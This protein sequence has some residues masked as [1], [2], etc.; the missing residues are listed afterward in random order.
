MPC[1]GCD[2]QFK[3]NSI[4][5]HLAQKKESCRSQY[6]SAEF[7]ELQK[8]CKQS[9]NMKMRLWNKR[10]ND[11]ACHENQLEET[12][13]DVYWRNKEPVAKLATKKVKIKPSAE[14]IKCVA[15]HQP[16]PINKILRHVSHVK[17][18][19]NRYSSKDLHQLRQ[20][21]RQFSVNAL[22]F[23]KQSKHIKAK[24][25]KKSNDHEKHKLSNYRALKRKIEDLH[26]KCVE[27]IDM[28]KICHYK[29]EYEK[30]KVKSHQE[31]QIKYLDKLELLLKQFDTKIKGLEQFVENR[32]LEIKCN[33]SKWCF[34][35]TVKQTAERLYED[36]KKVDTNC[37]EVINKVQ[38]V[39]HNVLFLFHSGL[40]EFCVEIG[41]NVKVN[42]YKYKHQH[43]WEYE[44]NWRRDENPDYQMPNEDEA[45]SRDEFIM[46]EVE[47]KIKQ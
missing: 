11:T 10:R 44:S 21:C 37:K 28:D 12:Y 27:A 39:Y 32:F 40:K 22:A 25:D 17:E 31:F 35:D 4:L 33:T 47:M 23:K 7:D 15:C 34:D 19:K 5:K 29:W 8:T 38:Q 9:S 1:I 6:S 36:M 14:V 41:V 46:R 2:G 42:P 45:K 18:C 43:K 3:R 26:L 20:K 13:Y 30:V 16:F 24:S